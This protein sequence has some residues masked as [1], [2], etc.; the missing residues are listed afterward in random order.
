MMHNIFF[1]SWHYS[2]FGLGVELVS[3]VLL[4]VQIWQSSSRL[5]VHFLCAISTLILNPTVLLQTYKLS[6]TV[7][8]FPQLAPC[9]CPYQILNTRC[10][11]ND[12]RQTCINIFLCTGTKVMEWTDWTA[13]VKRRLKTYL[14]IKNIDS[15][16]F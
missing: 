4:P 12:T 5:T 2:K 13:V 3:M 11:A 7:V 6:H 8:A 15:T 9:R 10:M 1:H 16:Y 14:V